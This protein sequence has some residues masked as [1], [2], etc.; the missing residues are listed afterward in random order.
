[1]TP[2][3]G[4]GRRRGT[5]GDRGAPGVRRSRAE[6]RDRAALRRHAVRTGALGR[7]RRPGGRALLRHPALAG[8][9]LLA[10]LGL[11]GT[12][13]WAA[14]ALGLARP[15]VVV[16]D[17]MR[18]AFAAGDL[19]LAVGAG[20]ASVRSGEVVAVPTGPRFTAHRVVATPVPVAGH[21][22]GWLL[23]LRGDVN[24]VEDAEPYA[25]GDRVLRVVAVAPGLGRVLEELARPAT[26]WPLGLGAIAFVILLVRL[27]GLAPA[28]RGRH[29][30]D[31]QPAD[32][33]ARSASE[34]RTSA[35]AIRRA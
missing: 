8:L 9:W 17:S 7:L 14:A 26:A 16:S 11:A 22:D 1:M 28:R 13:V 3:A 15:L 19:L 25:V 2:T 12:L 18:P 20:T 6:R 29:A 32:Q 33:R 5:W 21:G 27:A 34:R 30:R 23:R 10:G 31:R 24:P 35:R 4:S